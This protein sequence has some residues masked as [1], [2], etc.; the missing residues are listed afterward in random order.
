MKRLGSRRNTNGAKR[1][2][3]EGVAGCERVSGDRFQENEF[4]A[5]FSRVIF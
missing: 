4:V 5:F 1:G 2:E 3:K